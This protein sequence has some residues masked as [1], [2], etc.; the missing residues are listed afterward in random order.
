MRKLVLLPTIALLLFVACYRPELLDGFQEPTPEITA[1]ITVHV[2][3]YQAT[4]THHSASIILLGGLKEVIHP[5]T[6]HSWQNYVSVLHFRQRY[7]SDSNERGDV[8][9][10]DEGG[11]GWP[12]GKP[13]FPKRQIYG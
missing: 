12:D 4:H 2:C 1:L 13:M 9:I 3:A 6:P 7:A 5:L 8:R 10:A 11:C